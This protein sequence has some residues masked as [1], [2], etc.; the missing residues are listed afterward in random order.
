MRSKKQVKSKIKH[1]V[2]S[3][4]EF[5]HGAEMATIAGRLVML[6]QS[7]EEGD[8]DAMVEMVVLGLYME[9]IL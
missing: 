6:K 3:V 5:V 9:D 1:I 7:A 8:V 2:D 4:D